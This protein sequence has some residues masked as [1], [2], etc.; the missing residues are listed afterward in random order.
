[1]RK[2]KQQAISPNSAEFHEQR[3]HLE[4]YPFYW[5]VN[6]HARYTQLLEKEL[7]KFS[8]DIS[9]FRIMTLTWK[10]QSASMSQLAEFSVLKLPTVTKIVNRLRE[11]GLLDTQPCSS[12]GRVTIVRLTPQ[13]LELT[14]KANLQASKIFS[15]S[16]KG[17]KP[18][19]VNKM[20]ITLSMVLEN[21][22]D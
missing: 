8:L 2:I 9:K 5:V 3:F 12:D 15:K 10:Y 4:E 22:S 6:V 17:I 1:M 11:D 20:N 7:K 21:L 14:E 16:F 18:A 13:G 19:Q